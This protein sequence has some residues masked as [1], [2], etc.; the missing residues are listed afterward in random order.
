[1]SHMTTESTD[2]TGD[3]DDATLDPHTVA[4]V[5]VSVTLFLLCAAVAL[6]AAVYRHAPT[7]RVIVASGSDAPAIEA[8]GGLSERRPV[9]P[10]SSPQPEPPE[11]DPQ[12]LGPQRQLFVP[13]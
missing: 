11:H 1:M 13:L 3:A 10:A 9:A 8:L 2:A 6:A 7:A 5:L 4:S 12:P